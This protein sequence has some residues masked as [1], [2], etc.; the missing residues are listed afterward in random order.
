MK[1]HYSYAVKDELI[2]YF[3]GD[4]IAEMRI[5]DAGGIKNK[6][7]NNLPRAW[8]YADNMALGYF[9]KALGKISRC[10]ISSWMRDNCASAFMID[11]FT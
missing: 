5:S 7:E 8:A 9:L 11:S 1:K 4:T 3:P 2:K 10:V 6:Q